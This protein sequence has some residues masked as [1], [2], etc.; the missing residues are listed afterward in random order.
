MG[1]AEVDEVVRLPHL[2][3]DIATSTTEQEVVDVRC[4][5]PTTGIAVV[6]QHHDLATVVAALEDELTNWHETDHGH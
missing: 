4:S 3:K 6:D 2:V 1:T 5:S